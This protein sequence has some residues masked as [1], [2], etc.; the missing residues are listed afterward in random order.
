MQLSINFTC[1]VMDHS[2][3]YVPK[4]YIKNNQIAPYQNWTLTYTNEGTEVVK[5][6]PNSTDISSARI[7]AN[8]IIEQGN[9]TT[10]FSAE[11]LS[12][13]AALQIFIPTSNSQIAIDWDDTNDQYVI[14]TVYWSGTRGSAIF[15]GETYIFDA[16]PNGKS[17]K[18]GGPIDD[19]TE[20]GFIVGNA[21]L[22]QADQFPSTFNGPVTINGPTVINSSLALENYTHELRTIFNLF[23]P[24]GSYY[25]TSLPSSIN[26]HSYELDNLTPSEIA[27]CGSTWFDP[28]IVWGGTWEQDSAGRVTV[29]QST[30]TEF[31]TIGKT[32]GSKFIQNHA[33]SFTQPVP[34]IPKDA[35]T[36]ESTSV[37]HTH[38]P[39]G[40]TYHLATNA[41]AVGRRTIK[42]GTG[43]SYADNIYTTDGAIVRKT[44]TAGM[45]ANA[46]HT[47]KLPN[48]DYSITNRTTD[49]AVNGVQ[50]TSHGS[51]STGSSGN[52]QPYVVV[53]RW[54]R[55]A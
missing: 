25:E 36:T 50:T 24:V 32:A 34:K 10:L 21:G 16:T 31:D 5:I 47:H 26:G 17:F 7:E 28:R 27:L 15:T 38:G 37:A 1:P 35:I 19:S 29:A 54:H 46:N 18:I 22:P 2:K 40:A 49:G 33:H 11:D 42:N 41:S 48:A 12:E 23:Y 30:E 9:F 44:A 53:I 55:T 20:T 39:D 8:D 51:M 45:S 3:I 43:T 6:I 13:G 52:L 14:S 4:I